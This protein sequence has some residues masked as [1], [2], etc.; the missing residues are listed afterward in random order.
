MVQ[1]NPDGSW[2]IK[3]LFKRTGKRSWGKEVERIIRDPP[4]ED[5]L[6]RERYHKP[7]YIISL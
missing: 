1:N 4:F 6:K 2:N 3:Y 7:H 5:Q